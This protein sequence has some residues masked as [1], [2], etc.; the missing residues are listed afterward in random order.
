MRVDAEKVRSIAKADNLLAIRWRK[1]GVT[2]DSN[3]RFR[4]YPNLAE[5]LE[6]HDINQL[7]VAD[8]T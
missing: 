4:L 3:H 1:F 7:Q 5:S 2:T 8:L 6:L